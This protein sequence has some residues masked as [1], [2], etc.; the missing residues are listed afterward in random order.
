MGSKR[1]GNSDFDN[2]G[3]NSSEKQLK[4]SFKKMADN[5]FARYQQNS[6]NKYAKEVGFDEFKSLFPDLELPENTN[7]DKFDINRNNKIDSAE[8]ALILKTADLKDITDKKEYNN[9][10]VSASE[11]YE[12]LDEENPVTKSDFEEKKSAFRNLINNTEISDELKKKAIARINSGNYNSAY[13]KINDKGQPEVESLMNANKEKLNG[14]KLYNT[15][16]NAMDDYEFQLQKSIDRGISEKEF[17][18]LFFTRLAENGEIGEIITPENKNDAKINLD[19]FQYF[20]VDIEKINT[21]FNLAK[22]IKRVKSESY[23]TADFNNGKTKPDS[24][25]TT[26]VSK[27]LYSQPLNMKPVENSEMVKQLDGRLKKLLSNKELQELYENIDLNDTENIRANL[28][29]IA[30]K[31][32]KSANLNKP[33]RLNVI[34]DIKNINDGYFASGNKE[35]FDRVMLNSADRDKYES[36]GLTQKQAKI[37]SINKILGTLAHETFGHGSI[38]TWETNPPKNANKDDLELVK[39]SVLD[40]KDAFYITT[41]RS[42]EF[43]GSDELYRNQPCEKISFELGDEFSRHLNSQAFE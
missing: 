14:S 16:D 31:M 6:G 42:K 9:G 38:E 41:D 21:D 30:D 29:P 1:V 20:T 37:A 24:A 27:Y 34:K 40:Q 25:D 13:I 11:L 22:Y 5:I 43:T 3:L 32:A 2:I 18:K 10:I 17:K 12:A 4:P 33:V 8:L 36:L 26:A 23:K 15:T 35:N 28:Q 19:N 7:L 39:Q